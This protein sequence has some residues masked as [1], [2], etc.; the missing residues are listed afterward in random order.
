MP[1]ISP[2]LSVIALLACAGQPEPVQEVPAETSKGLSEMSELIISQTASSEEPIS[3]GRPDGVTGDKTPWPEDTLEG[4][5][6]WLAI[7]GGLIDTPHS[8][9][10]PSY[11]QGCNCEGL[12]GT[13]LGLVREGGPI[14]VSLGPIELAW[15]SREEGARKVIPVDVEDSARMEWLVSPT[16]YDAEALSFSKEE[17]EAGWSWSFGSHMAGVLRVLPGDGPE[18]VLI[19]YGD[20]SQVLQ[21]RAASN[22]LVPEPVGAWRVG[23][24]T[25]LGLVSDLDGTLSFEALVVSGESARLVGLIGIDLDY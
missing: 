7:G 13:N 24:Q 12:A 22:A 11:A 18:G 20:H 3:A 25:I 1:R 19:W 16:F 4:V 9:V 23:G 14:S 2:V 10:V 6:G 8:L 17:S 5:H 15:S 21:T